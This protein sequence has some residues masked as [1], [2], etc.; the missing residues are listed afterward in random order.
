M[1]KVQQTKVRVDS[2]KERIKTD[3]EFSI[4]CMLKI[5]SFQTEEEKVKDKSFKWNRVGFNGVDGQFLSSVSNQY[6]KKGKISVKQIKA[7]K[8]CMVKYAGQIDKLESAN[9]MYLDGEQLIFPTMAEKQFPDCDIVVLDKKGEKEYIP[10]NGSLSRWDQAV[11]RRNQEYEQEQKEQAERELREKRQLTSG[12][13]FV[14]KH[15]TKGRE[16]EP[17][18]ERPQ[19]L[20]EKERPDPFAKLRHWE[21]QN[22][23]DKE[24]RKASEKGLLVKIHPDELEDYLFGGENAKAK[25][26]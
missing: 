17:R 21:L 16:I 3:D 4:K 13:A 7:M 14:K 19:I 6:L 1:T 11:A 15:F 23:L 8:K 5:F 12:D 22:R 25:E 26:K 9:V 20:R 24:T 2:I 18:P 10:Y